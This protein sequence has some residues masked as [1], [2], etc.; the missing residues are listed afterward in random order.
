MDLNKKII[1]AMENPDIVKIMNK[2]SKSFAIDLD[3]DTIHTCHLNAL[4]KCFVNYKSSFNTKFTTY[5]YKGVMIECIKEIK[6]HNKMSKCQPINENITSET[7]EDKLTK[8]YPFILED[9]MEILEKE[10]DK[11]ILHDR[12][13]NFTIQEIAEKRGY[14]RETARKRLKNIYE[15]I[16]MNLK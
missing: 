3:S 16:K 13:C 7:E 1:N 8:L 2:A 9:C 15:K 4:W 12:L 11:S 10:E 5:L 6:F 14:S